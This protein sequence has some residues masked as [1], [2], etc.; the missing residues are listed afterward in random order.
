MHLEINIL[1]IFYLKFMADSDYLRI[2]RAG[3]IY[4]N[5]NI[6]GS[7]PSIWSKYYY[8]Y[9]RCLTKQYLVDLKLVDFSSIK[10]F[11]LDTSCADNQLVPLEYLN[12][13]AITIFLINWTKKSINNF[14]IY[15]KNSDLDKNQQQIEFQG[16]GIQPMGDKNP[17]YHSSGSTVFLTNKDILNHGSGKIVI[18]TSKTNIDYKSL[19]S[20]NFKFT[21]IHPIWTEKNHM[22]DSATP[23]NSS[24]N[25]SISISDPGGKETDY[26]LG[27]SLSFPDSSPSSTNRGLFLHIIS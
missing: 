13:P 16:G 21:S 4:N 9:D 24:T 2:A 19:S 26:L 12:G 6:A 7:S 11:G 20:Y 27:N 5:Y 17:S 23:H 10:R 25:I 14:E 8:N 15:F 1:K 18:D 3:E 22:I